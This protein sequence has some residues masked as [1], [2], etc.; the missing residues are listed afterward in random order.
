MPAD[1]S[2]A[3][4]GKALNVVAADVYEAMRDLEAEEYG[5]DFVALALLQDVDPAMVSKKRTVSEWLKRLTQRLQPTD[6]QSGATRNPP[7]TQMI[8]PHQ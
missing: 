8:Q 4:A 5:A 1:A 3:P 7:M 2:F 6:A